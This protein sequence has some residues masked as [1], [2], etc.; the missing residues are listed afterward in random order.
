MTDRLLD[1]RDLAVTL[2]GCGR[3]LRPVQGIDLHLALGET[4]CLVG[5][6]GCGKSL[7]ALALM[8]LLPPTMSRQAATLQLAGEDLLAA[9]PARW[10]ALRGDRMAMIFQDANTALNPVLTIGEQLMEIWQAHRPGSAAAARQRAIT[11]LDMVG[12]PAAAARLG[13]YPHQL[14]GGLRQRVGIA[15]ALMCDPALL[16]ADEPTTA[17][18]VTIQAQTLH[19][20]A[21]LCRQFNAGLIFITHDLGVVARIADR[22]AVMYAGQIVETAATAE[23]FA[24]PRHPYTQGLLRALPVPGRQ[25]PRERMPTI[26]GTVPPPVAVVEACLFADRC[27]AAHAMCRAG[28]VAFRQHGADHATRCV[29]APDASAALWA[30]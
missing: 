3:A 1:V 25:R 15:M 23:L 27:S 11:S 4:L 6:S 30:A 22:V 21:R 19:V 16:I 29:L 9:S 28:P 8:G 12:V 2:H 5:E 10:E 26:P 7:T 24:R 13:Q 18:D 14:S 20:L 17:L